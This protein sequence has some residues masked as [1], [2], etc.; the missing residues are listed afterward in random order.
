VR[1]SPRKY[2]RPGIVGQA[3]LWSESERL[4]NYE[5]YSE[6]EG[7]NWIPAVR[8]G[9]DIQHCIAVGGRSN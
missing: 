1:K 5:I 4:R 8:K 3:I 7:S 6:V 2:K 9:S